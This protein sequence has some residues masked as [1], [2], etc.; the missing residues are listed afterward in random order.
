MDDDNDEPLSRGYSDWD[1]DRKARYDA[2]RDRVAA[3]IADC[4]NILREDGFADDPPYVQG[5]VVAAEWTNVE[6]ER[7]NWGGRETIT[8]HGQMLSTGLGLSAWAAHRHT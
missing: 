3:G 5:W 8:P 1:D 2:A 4:V 6:A 7:D